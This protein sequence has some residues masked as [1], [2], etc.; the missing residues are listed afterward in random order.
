M[1][2]REETEAD[3]YG[4]TQVEYGKVDKWSS[5]DIIKAIAK[6][7]SWDEWK[8]VYDATL[9]VDSEEW[10]FIDNIADGKKKVALLFSHGHSQ[11]FI[12][13]QL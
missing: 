13:S 3:V 8:S 7:Q 10:H 4:G 9:D 5:K 2:V 1:L 12:V 6:A 11:T